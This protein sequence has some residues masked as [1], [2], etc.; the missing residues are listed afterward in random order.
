MRTSSTAWSIMAGG[1]RVS[2]TESRWLPLSARRALREQRE[3][4]EAEEVQTAQKAAQAHPESGR[5]RLDGSWRPSG[6]RG[7][8]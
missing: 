4:M 8:V 2:G 6:R 1:L 5:G 3:R 7:A